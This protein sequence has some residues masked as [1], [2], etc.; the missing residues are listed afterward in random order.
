MTVRQ[1]PASIGI[2]DL[3]AAVGQGPTNGRTLTR[4]EAR[5]ALDAIMD[6]EAT[7]AQAGALLLLQRYRGEAP[8]ELLGY[9]DA[10]RARAMPFHP[11]VEGLLDV[12]SPYD[13]RSKHVVVSPAAS[14]VAAA[15]GVPVLMHG[16]RDLG[17]KRGL[18]VGDVIAALGV[19]T[20]LE[21]AAVERGIEACG[22]GYLRQARAV[23][24][25]HAL[26]PLR[27]ELGLR[28][29]LH[30]VEKVCDLARAPYH[31]LGVAHMPYLKQ[32][33]PVVAGL[34][35]RRTL[36]VQGIE[37]HEDVATSRGTR[38][39]EI[40]EAG[41]QRESRLDAAE[42]GL[43]PATDDDLAPG[44]AERSARMT[45]AVLEGRAGE[46]ERDL[47]LLNAALRIHLG[48]RAGGL[49]SALDRAR[50]ALTSGAAL[51]TLGAWRAVA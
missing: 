6:G 26:K 49:P 11:R 38:I 17:P 3:V 27:Q 41:V 24:A 46:T 4:E 13:G 28:T 18:A 40:D 8:S 15:A 31:L 29:P 32:L 21:P 10:V 20:D 5:R 36:V 30:M 2:R 44:D 22:L 42:L 39:V 1:P 14:I 12:G 19:A 47:V 16:E 43:A 50:E 45:V 35:W 48:G 23:P 25:L 9:I 33:A 34:G 7:P 51:R 37:G